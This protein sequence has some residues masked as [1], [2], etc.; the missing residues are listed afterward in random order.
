MKYKDMRKIL[1]LIPESVTFDRTVNGE[2]YLCD[3][4]R[5]VYNRMYGPQENHWELVIGITD[6][7]FEIFGKVNGITFYREGDT[8]DF[9]ENMVK[10]MIDMKEQMR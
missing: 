3:R 10:I 7:F 9:Q 8:K 4:L 1:D 6:R 2:V 5:V